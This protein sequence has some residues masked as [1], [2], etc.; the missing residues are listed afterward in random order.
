MKNLSF[1][2]LLLLLS[3][4]KEKVT[5][6]GGIYFNVGMNISFVDVNGEDLLNQDN[7]N[8]FNK[9]DIFLY[10]QVNGKKTLYST[11]PMMDAPNG[12]IYNCERPLCI[13]GIQKLADTTYL[14]LSDFIT[15]TIYS[16]T[17]KNGGNSYTSI[18][19]YNGKFLWDIENGGEKYFTIVK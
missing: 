9:N 10:H 7:P 16:E 5:T 8:A 13:I 6:E 18:I 4:C 15:D 3:S 17:V 19:W 1:L 2:I 14:E 12:I 11:G